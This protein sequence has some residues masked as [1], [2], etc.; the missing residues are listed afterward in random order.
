MNPTL[1]STANSTPDTHEVL[2]CP[3]ALIPVGL[4]LGA[5]LIVLVHLGFFGSG[6]GPDQGAAA[7]VWQI[8]MAAQIPAIAL[9]TTRWFSKARRPACNVLA[10]HGLAIAICIGIAALAPL[11]FL[12]L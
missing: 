1:N 8:L 11:Y 9:F 3:T 12:H 4:A 5:L 6:R 10:M 2:C 7:H